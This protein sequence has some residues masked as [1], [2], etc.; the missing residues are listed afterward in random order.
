MLLLHM[1][2]SLLLVDV[3]EV[4]VLKRNEDASQ[5]EQLLSKLTSKV[6]FLI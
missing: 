1:F 4:F 2:L 3:Y 5:Q 6:L